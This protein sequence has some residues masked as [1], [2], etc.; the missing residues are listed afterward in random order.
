MG[1]IRVSAVGAALLL[2]AAC[3]TSTPTTSAPP[4]AAPK[5][6]KGP[7]VIPTDHPGP[8][9]YLAFVRSLNYGGRSLSGDDDASLLA[10]GKFACKILGERQSFSDA[11]GALLDGSVQ[12]KPSMGE[13]ATLMRAS[14]V[15]LCP[16][17]MNLIQNPS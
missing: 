6:S 1:I 3:G 12:P 2:L 9:T 7:T 16:Q 17:Y 5:Y 8:A 11:G 4:P 13:I 14:V 10:Q 15:H